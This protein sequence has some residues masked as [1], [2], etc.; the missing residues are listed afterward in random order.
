MFIINDYLK[1]KEGGRLSSLK[2]HC[3]SKKYQRKNVLLFVYVYIKRVGHKSRES[4]DEEE[5]VSRERE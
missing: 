3:V 4:K 1:S 2:H 5:E